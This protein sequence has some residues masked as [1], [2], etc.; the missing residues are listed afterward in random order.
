MR[1]ASTQEFAGCTDHA[2]EA[3]VSAASAANRATVTAPQARPRAPSRMTARPQAAPIAISAICTHVFGASSVPPVAANT[4]NPKPVARA[5]PTTT[6]AVRPRRRA[7]LEGTSPAGS[8]VPRVG[9]VARV[10]TPRE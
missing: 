9:A 7:P 6:S 4:I 3:Y 8:G 2:I 5:T 10:D 1:F